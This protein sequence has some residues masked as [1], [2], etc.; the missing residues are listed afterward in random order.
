MDSR[1]SR[2][3]QLHWAV[4]PIAQTG[5]R[6]GMLGQAVAVEA[7]LASPGAPSCSS[8]TLVHGSGMQSPEPEGTCRA[9][10]VT[11]ARAGQFRI[12][13][14]TSS[15]FLFHMPTCFEVY[16]MFPGIPL[17]ILWMY[18]CFYFLSNPIILKKLVSNTLNWNRYI[19]LDN[20]LLH[21]LSY[22]IYWSE[23]F[24]A[25]LTSYPNTKKKTQIYY[26]GLFQCTHRKKYGIIVVHAHKF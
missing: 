1:D 3:V 16:K 24:R 7:A 2:A 9:A 14:Q 19:Y 22:K 5:L 4:L 21:K 12:I 10:W 6:A 20:F 26:L 13:F 15:D 18:L 17:G 11:T 23:S 8:F 25:I